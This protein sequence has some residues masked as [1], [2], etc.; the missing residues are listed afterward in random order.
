MQ[1]IADLLESEV[2]RNFVE[3]QFQD[4]TTTNGVLLVMKVYQFVEASNP[5]ASRK[6]RVQLTRELIND[7]HIRALARDQMIQCIE[8]T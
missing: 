4:S 6:R 2:G 5:G 3:N 1:D 8:E 7:K